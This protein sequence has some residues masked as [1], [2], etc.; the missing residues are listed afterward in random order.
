MKRPTRFRIIF[1]PPYIW[2]NVARRRGDIDRCAGW[3]SRTF[4]NQKTTPIS[5]R[6]TSAQAVQK[7]VLVGAKCAIHDPRAVISPYPSPPSLKPRRLRPAAASA[8]IVRD[9]K[10]ER[11]PRQ[12]SLQTQA[13]LTKCGIAISTS[14]PVSARTWRAGAFQPRPPPFPPPRSW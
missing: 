1:D 13:A 6:G 2:I 8:P 12:G 5:P 4:V 9:L 14:A 3:G 11:L 7:R 10:F